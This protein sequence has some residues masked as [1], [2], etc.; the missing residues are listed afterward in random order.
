MSSEDIFSRFYDN[1]GSDLD[2]YEVED[3]AAFDRFLSISDLQRVRE[4][5]L[6]LA[7]YL[8][9]RDALA[10]HQGEDPTGGR[11]G[12]EREPYEMITTYLK[13]DFNLDDELATSL[14]QNLGKLWD[15]WDESS[16]SISYSDE[17]RSKLRKDQSN[18]CKNCN[19]RLGSEQNSTAFTNDDP[20]KPIHEYSEQQTSPELDHIEPLSHLGNNS[21]EN[22]QVLCRF[23]NQGKNN[24]RQVDIV[25]QLEFATTKVEGMK[26]SHRRKMFFAATAGVE[27]CERCGDTR[28]ELTVR[29]QNASGCYI[30]PNLEAVCVDCVYNSS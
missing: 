20:Y 21:I 16:R 5:V 19:V 12:S 29:K 14:G 15:D 22:F 25:D 4:S 8:T 7:A 1:L 6:R 26:R 9:P 28:E 3:L 24:K 27:E 10:K 11:F 18:R 30:V 17:I 23:C 13:E 2:D